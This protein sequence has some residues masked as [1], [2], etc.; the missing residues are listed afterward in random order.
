MEN[1]VY[2]INGRE[3]EVLGELITPQ[4]FDFARNALVQ[5]A[6]QYSSMVEDKVNS[7]M[8]SFNSGDELV[9][10]LSV[11]LV[12]VEQ[13]H[14]S[15]EAM[16]EL[17]EFWSKKL[18]KPDVLEEVVADFFKKNQSWVGYS[19]LLRA[20]QDRALSMIQNKAI[21]K[22]LSKDLDKI[23]KNLNLDSQNK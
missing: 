2:K 19:P 13:D 10:F 20:T 7:V 12:P 16:N 23:M 15:A 22:I 1:K 18:P 3:F 9:E 11:I 4:H 8:L 17:K 6:K 21:E 5:F 14:F